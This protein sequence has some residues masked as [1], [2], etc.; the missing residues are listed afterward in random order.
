MYF[1]EIK[2][3]KELEI[4]TALVT[5]HIKM[6]HRTLTCLKNCLPRY[7]VAML[8]RFFLLPTLHLM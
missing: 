1:T 6:I 8:V 2:L 4:I 3:L 5:D 7:V